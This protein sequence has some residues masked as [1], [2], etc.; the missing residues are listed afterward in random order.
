[1]YYC[2]HQL[3][4]TEALTVY[5]V[6]VSL[7]HTLAVFEFTRRTSFTPKRPRDGDDLRPRD[8]TTTVMS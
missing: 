8:E 4:L 2:L 6:V 5:V 3:L 7:E 1:M